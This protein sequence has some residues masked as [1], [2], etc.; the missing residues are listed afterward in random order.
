MSFRATVTITS[1]LARVTVMLDREGILKRF[2]QH[3][4]IKLDR[5]AQALGVT[6]VV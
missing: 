5:E 3:I 6:C 2:G 4:G 1:F